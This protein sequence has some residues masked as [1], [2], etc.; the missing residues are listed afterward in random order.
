M[1]SYVHADR[2]N[3]IIV[4]LD[5]YLIRLDRDSALRLAADIS[6]V[7]GEIARRQLDDHWRLAAGTEQ[8]A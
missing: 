3:T 4:V 1:R 6:D 2:D 5:D 7:A 8:D